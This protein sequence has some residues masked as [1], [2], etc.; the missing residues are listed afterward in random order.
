MQLGFASAIIPDLGLD[1]VLATASE[2]GYDCIELMCWPLGKAERRYAGV[3]HIDVDQLDQE[4]ADV[5]HLPS[6]RLKP[7]I[8]ASILE[9]ATRP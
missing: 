9:W 7:E 8:G 4:A 6:N 2:I 1:E 3:T 5:A